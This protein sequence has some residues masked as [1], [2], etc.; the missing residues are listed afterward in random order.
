MKLMEVKVNWRSLPV[1]SGLENE[2]TCEFSIIKRKELMLDQK[3][4]LM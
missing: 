3:I 4:I 2:L 1:S